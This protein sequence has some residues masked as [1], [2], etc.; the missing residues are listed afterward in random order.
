MQKISSERFCETW[1]S[2]PN[3]EAVCRELDMPPKRASARASYYRSTGIPLR[4]FKKNDI[5][6]LRKLVRGK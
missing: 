5:P 1:Q 4:D 2:S 6:K 3:L